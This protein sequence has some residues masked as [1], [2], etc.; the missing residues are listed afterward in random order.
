MNQGAAIAVDKRQH[1]Q[2]HGI[3]PSPDGTR[4]E[5]LPG[6]SSLHFGRG[7]VAGDARS[8]DYHGGAYGTVISNEFSLAGK[9]YADQPK[10]YFNFFK[11]GE[12]TDS[13]TS[14]DHA[15][16]SISDNGLSLIHI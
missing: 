2:G 14:R 10:L 8:Y 16:M 4:T 1:D 15:I 7:H 6:H 3:P 13:G 11:E 12:V 9:S 5:F